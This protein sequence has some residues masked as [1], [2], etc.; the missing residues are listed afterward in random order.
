MAG[1]PALALAQVSTSAWALQPLLNTRGVNLTDYDQVIIK[2]AG[3][4]I[5]T[6]RQKCKLAF[7]WVAGALGCFA[8]FRWGSQPQLNQLSNVILDDG[9]QPQELL[10]MGL[11][12]DSSLRAHLSV[13]LTDVWCICA[14]IWDASIAL[15]AGSSL[16][17]GAVSEQQKEHVLPGRTHLLRRSLSEIFVAQTSVC[18]GCGLS[19]PVCLGC[20]YRWGNGFCCSTLGKSHGL[21]E[22]CHPRRTSKIPGASGVCRA[23]VSARDAH[24]DVFQCISY[25]IK[26]A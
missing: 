13:V 6:L 5:N 12:D 3:C 16:L 11:P 8:E 25:D 20:N 18:K 2:E 1:L 17:P 9:L 21:Q 23:N 24:M 15:G 14:Y 26:T 10:P 19:S 22:S 4:G 7:S